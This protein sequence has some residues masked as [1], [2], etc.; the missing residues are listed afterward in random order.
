[1]GKSTEVATATT[2]LPA[3][4]T[5]GANLFKRVAKASSYLKRLQL[6]SKGRAVNKRLVA[7]GEFGV[8]LSDD[9]VRVLGDK[10]DMI[11]FAARA[12]AIDMSDRKNIIVHYDA[13]SEVFKDIEARSFTKDSGCMFGIVFLAFSREYGDFVEYFC[14]TKSAR[15]EAAK[16]QP[17]L[18]V[19]EADVELAKAEGVEL[20]VQPPKPV[21]F[22]SRLKEAENFSWHIATYTPCSQP[23]TNLPPQEE[24]VMA[25]TKFLSEPST[26]LEAAE[27]ESEE[28][29]TTERVR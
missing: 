6:F 17:F 3:T 20:R 14:G 29:A 25:I 11:V 16:L 7:P 18:P 13:D 22:G 28:A 2:Q 26:N 21:T 5:G 8:P 4:R 23:F 19:S 9:E 24:I 12:K 27:E 1:M 15:A 10:C